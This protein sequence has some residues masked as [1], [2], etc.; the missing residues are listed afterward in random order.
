[1]G[2]P[3]T[4]RDRTVPSLNTFLDSASRNGVGDGPT[5]LS[6]P[7]KDMLDLASK[8]VVTA[9]DKDVDGFIAGTSL[10]ALDLDRTISEMSGNA[11]IANMSLQS[12]LQYQKARSKS[13]SDPL[14]KLQLIQYINEV[15]ARVQ[16]HR[17]R[18]KLGS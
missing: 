8:S 4:A 17:M 16:V 14:F 1:M 7:A 18:T 5:V 6:G 11:P 10:I 15:S 9:V 12:D 2:E 3:L 13:L